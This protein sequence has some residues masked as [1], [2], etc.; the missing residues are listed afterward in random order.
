MV[1]FFHPATVAMR[2]N[3]VDEDLN[4]GLLHEADQKEEQYEAAI[5]PIPMEQQKGTKAEVTPIFPDTPALVVE[6]VKK[7]DYVFCQHCSKIGD[8]KTAM[9]PSQ[10]KGGLMICSVCHDFYPCKNQE[11]HG[12]KAEDYISC[13]DCYT[14]GDHK[15]AMCP[16]K[17]KKRVMVCSVCRDLYPCKNQEEHGNNGVE[18]NNFC[19]RCFRNGHLPQ[20]CTEDYDP[21]LTLN[22]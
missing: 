11:E 7:D 3:P 15:T 9:C 22:E 16:N 10:P 17:P 19:Y 6:Q 18:V 8:H 13:R 4:L 20:E 12:N 21:T 2:T 1:L 14:I 5:S